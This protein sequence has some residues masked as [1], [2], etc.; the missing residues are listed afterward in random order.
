MPVRALPAPY[1]LT[2]T[3]GC[4]GNKQAFIIKIESKIL[5]QML[6]KPLAIWINHLH[7]TSQPE[8]WEHSHL[9]DLSISDAQPLWGKHV[10]PL[11]M[12]VEML[13]WFKDPTELCLSCPLC[14]TEFTSQAK[15]GVPGAQNMNFVSD[16]SCS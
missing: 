16:L 2:Q 11:Q 1:Q 12:R 10:N 5:N 7:N 6:K 13:V 9:S 3:C 15:L 4:K 14:W 8:H